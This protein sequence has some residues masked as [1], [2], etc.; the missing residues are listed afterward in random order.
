[1][2]GS[3]RA[4]GEG[5]E[6]S[7]QLEAAKWKSMVFEI[8]E[9]LNGY[10]RLGDK[11][12]DQ[13]QRLADKDSDEP[14]VGRNELEVGQE[15]MIRARIKSG[16][17]SAV[18]SRSGATDGLGS[19][20]MDIAQLRAEMAMLESAQNEQELWGSTS[21][22]PLQ[23]SSLSP[24]ARGGFGSS[25]AFFRHLS[26]AGDVV[27]IASGGLTPRTPGGA[28]HM[29]SPTP[30]TLPSSPHLTGSNFSG[31]SHRRMQSAVKALNGA[32]R[33]Q[34]AGRLVTMD[35][36]PRLSPARLAESSDEGAAV[37]A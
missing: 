26:S 16:K 14:S 30:R 32:L 25:S 6:R 34:Q 2:S 35:T 5:A 23:G 24:T 15:A 20:S 28:F 18:L 13:A 36:T 10:V 19:A 17:M 22:T 12:E 21:P 11:L 9:L 29:P 33:L 37:S 3:P 1:M 7:L 8:E 27:S 4:D 31:G